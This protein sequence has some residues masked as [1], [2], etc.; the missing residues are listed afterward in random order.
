MFG[1]S[2]APKPSDEAQEAAIAAARQTVRNIIHELFHASPDQAE[3]LTDKLKSFLQ[4]D[5]ILPFDYKQKARDKARELEC[6]AN[7]RTADKLMQQ[8]VRLAASEQL[9]ERSKKLGDARRYSSKACMLGADQ[10]WRK[11]FD[12]LNETAMLTG[13]IHRPGP[14]RAKPQDFA[15]A[16]PN[17]AKGNVPLKH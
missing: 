10:D 5:K 13:G 17:R 1:L 12:R 15:P 14:S 6:N 8:A 9:S 2:K 16:T 11:A 4:A 7:M 3:K